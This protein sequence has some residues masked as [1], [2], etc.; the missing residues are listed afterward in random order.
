MVQQAQALLLLSASLLYH[1]PLYLDLGDQGP[2]KGQDD[3]E[4]AQGENVT[5]LSE[6]MEAIHGVRVKRLAYMLMW[7][8]EVNDNRKVAKS[9]FQAPDSRQLDESLSELVA[10]MMHDNVLLAAAADL[11]ALLEVATAPHSH[12]KSLH[13]VMSMAKLKAAQR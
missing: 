4:S 12:L 10:F 9:G 11:Q 3:L 1:L 8:V 7:I 13:T 5:S 2:R 6:T